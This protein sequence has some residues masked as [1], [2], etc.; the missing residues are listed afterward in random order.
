MTGAGGSIGRALRERLD[1]T[2]GI[3][4]SYLVGRRPVRPTDRAVDVADPAA[5][6][7]AVAS[8]APD[9]VIHLAGLSGA[10]CDVDLD[11]TEA[12]NVGSVRTLMDAA[13]GLGVSRVIFSSSSAVYGDS[14]PTPSAEDRDLAGL[15]TYARSKIEGE[16]AVRERVSPA[17]SGIALRTFNVHGPG[18]ENS[19]VNRL[20]ASSDAD[21]VV[22]HGLDRFVRDYIHVDDVVTAIILSLTAQVEGAFTAVNI[23]SGI[24]T[25]NREL[26]EALARDRP[27]PVRIAADVVSYSCADITLARRLLGFAPVGS[28]A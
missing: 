28:I 1:R 14:Y 12:V 2:P 5:L 27:V 13:D 23:G 18:F 25:T 8:A 7:A 9:A 26:L 16:S 24:P 21:P 22:L 4:P 10:A 6:A 15:T 11:R 17:M 3:L 20:R 19:L